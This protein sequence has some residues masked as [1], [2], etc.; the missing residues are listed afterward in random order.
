MALNR[1][2]IID[3]AKSNIGREDANETLMGTFLNLFQTELALLHDWSF[4]YTSTTGAFTEDQISYSWPSDMKTLV[5]FSITGN[6]ARL[7][8]PIDARYAD[9]I[10]PDVSEL[11]SEVP[12]SFIDRG[13]TYDV[14]PPPGDSYPWE[15]NYV[16]WP[17]EMTSDSDTPDFLNM[18]SILITGLSMHMS[19][20]LGLIE[21]AD[22]FA[23][24]L[25]SNYPM[26]N[27]KRGMVLQA[28]GADRKRTPK[29]QSRRPYRV[30]ST[31]RPSNY[32]GNPYYRGGK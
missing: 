27:Q 32:L 31:G 20:K 30:E 4:L 29:E 16:K 15:M 12:S 19:R 18:D 7:I 1:G 10:Y 2:Q 21:D 14:I 3:T 23:A 9:Q 13:T 26:G 8:H 6:Y 17:S 22:S 24:M 11:S 28:I 5:T 25:Y